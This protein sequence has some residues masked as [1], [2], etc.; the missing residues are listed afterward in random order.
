MTEKK[1]AALA[2]IEEYAIVAMG[3]SIADIMAENLGDDGLSEFSLDRIRIPAGGGIAFEIPTLE[4]S[5]SAK[6]IEGVVVGWKTVRGY[7]ANAYDGSNNPPDCSSNDGEVGMGDPGGYCSDCPL[8][9]WG[10]DPKGGK[11]K[12]CAEKRMLFVLR[13]DDVL[14]IVIMVPPTSLKGIREYFRS[15]HA[16][17]AEE[18]PEF[19]EHNLL[20]ACTCLRRTAFRRR[21]LGHA[22][23]GGTVEEEYVEDSGDRRRLGVRGG[24]PLAEI[25]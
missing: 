21:R 20:G 24:A 13:K 17:F 7:Y 3:D 9:A 15:G 12:A 8:N 23:R 22:R 2:K 10:S 14:P 1:E 11:G 18:S 6:T 16:V 19:N 25:S 4:G 5:D